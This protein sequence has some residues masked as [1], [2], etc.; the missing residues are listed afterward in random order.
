M[1]IDLMTG[2]STWEDSAGLARKLEGAG[3]DGMLPTETTQV[4]WMQ[5]AAASM[6]APSL[7]FTTGRIRAKFRSDELDTIGDLITDEMLDHFAVLAPWDEVANT[8]IDRYAGRATRV[9]MYLAEHRMRT[10]PQHLARWGEE[11][12]A[13][14]EA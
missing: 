4:H 8:L 1:Q 14:Q 3:F 6:A 11:A 13:V 12:Q 5:I 9:M 10:D 7:S 2:A